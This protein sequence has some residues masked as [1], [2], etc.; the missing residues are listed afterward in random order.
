VGVLICIKLPVLYAIMHYMLDKQYKINELRVISETIEGETIIIDLD[1]GNYY[2]V[3]KSAAIIWNQIEMNN[4]TNNILQSVLNFY[5]TNEDT[6]EKSVE[7]I[8]KFLI[9]NNL[10]SEV[11][12]V[13]SLSKIEKI[14]N[15]KKELFIIPKI[16]KYDDM[17]EML[18]ADPVHDV[19][20]NDGWPNL[21]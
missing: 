16:E 19:S 6:A 18:L 17:K 11:D 12:L 13:V 9:T 14:S 4:P 20:E 10:I 15:N 8:I 3:N 21:K 2:S 7:E 1:T 5:D